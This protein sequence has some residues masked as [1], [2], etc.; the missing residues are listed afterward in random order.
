MRLYLSLVKQHESP[1]IELFKK[2]KIKIKKIQPLIS[3]I[4]VSPILDSIIDVD[5]YSLKYF[6]LP[7][8]WRVRQG[9][10]IGRSID[11][12]QNSEN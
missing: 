6:Q 1:D 3:E 8:Y 2:L 5:G 11:T 9:G 4:A 10:I 12:Y 7:K